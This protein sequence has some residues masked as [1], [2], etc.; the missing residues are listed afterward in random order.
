MSTT[1]QALDNQ[2][3]TDCTLRT[4]TEQ[5]ICTLFLA[6]LRIRDHH[7][8]SVGV[9]RC[10]YNYTA[11]RTPTVPAWTLVTL[12]GK[13]EHTPCAQNRHK[14]G[15]ISALHMKQ[16]EGSLYRSSRLLDFVVNTRD[17]EN[18]EVRVSN[19]VIDKA[20]SEAWKV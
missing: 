4:K 12:Q 5:S 9:C 1:D 17:Q 14:C 3:S 16:G 10:S 8:R 19:T 7:L 15:L 6:L 18:F 11:A 20:H 13:S 2:L